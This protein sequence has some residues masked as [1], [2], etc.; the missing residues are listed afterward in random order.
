[1]LVRGSFNPLAMVDPSPT[2]AHGT[3]APPSSSVLSRVGIGVLFITSIG[4]PGLCV[5]FGLLYFVLSPFG[6]TPLATRDM[7][8]GGVFLVL[9][10]GVFMIPGA[11][12]FLRRR[13]KQG[14]PRKRLDE[15][16]LLALAETPSITPA[17]LGAVAAGTESL[18]QLFGA[19]VVPPPVPVRL[20]FSVHSRPWNRRAW[21]LLPLVLFAAPAWAVL[22]G[23]RIGGALFLYTLASVGIGM[24]VGILQY[25]YVYRR[26]MVID[27][28][29]VVYINMFGRA[30]RVSRGEVTRIALRAL[31]Y[32]S[33]SQDRMFFLGLGG[34]CI[35][36][37]A[38]FGIPYE[39]ASYLAAV[40]RV[41]ID[42][43]WD[44][45]STL[46]T[47]YTEFV[48][49]ATWSERHQ[50]LYGLAVMTPILLFAL[51]ITLLRYAR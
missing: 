8:F 15:E 37:V 3:T 46:K 12:F 51:G 43:T 48:G 50:F 41:P 32:R 31:R 21:W 4:L 29:N 42:P 24:G 7:I 35:L 6:D 33:G 36:R 11:I 38:R 26:Q 45:P 40:L 23:Y 34:E 2:G 49:A 39:E 25:F 27:D 47:L 1:M 13:R 30:K 17:K 44:R 10:G 22:Q 19:P 14:R 16:T 5:V 28:L 9:T 18:D 20:P